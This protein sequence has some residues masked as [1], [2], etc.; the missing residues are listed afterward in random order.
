L[1]GTNG[2]AGGSYHVLTHTNVAVALG[3][4]TVLGP[5]NFD[6]SGNF[7]FT[8]VAPTGPQRFY[9]LQVP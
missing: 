2:P 5:F 7:S 8:N 6:G 4:W 3:S 9:L 1:S